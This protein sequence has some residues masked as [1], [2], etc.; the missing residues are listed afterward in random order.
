MTVTYTRLLFF[1]KAGSVLPEMTL[2]SQVPVKIVHPLNL[3]LQFVP[4]CFLQS[5]PLGRAFHQSLVSFG[6]P[7]NLRLQLGRKM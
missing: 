5:F 4:H 3:S 1:L 7:L 6:Y 2:T